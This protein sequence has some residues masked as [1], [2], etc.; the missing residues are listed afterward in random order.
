MPP[1]GAEEA[2]NMYRRA[3]HATIPN[4]AATQDADAD[5]DYAVDGADS[6]GRGHVPKLIAEKQARL[7]RAER[8][9]SRTHESR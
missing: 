5:L 1:R 4:A 8:L 7:R 2:T 9:L 6:E 3:T